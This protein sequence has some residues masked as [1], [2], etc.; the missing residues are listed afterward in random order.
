MYY[1]TQNTQ[2]FVDGWR[3]GHARRIVT[4]QLGSYVSAFF[5]YNW[6]SF[7]TLLF[8]D[9]A[10]ST[11]FIFPVNAEIEFRRRK[12]EKQVNP[13]ILATGSTM[14]ASIVKMAWEREEAR[15]RL[16]APTERCFVAALICS[17]SSEKGG[18]RLALYQL[19]YKYDRIRPQMR[20]VSY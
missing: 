17:H 5:L 9:P 6:L 18:K 4:G 14:L 16:V 12:I 8:S 11:R 19:T 2:G 1:L 20:W 3:F 10:R 7:L 13:L 15:L